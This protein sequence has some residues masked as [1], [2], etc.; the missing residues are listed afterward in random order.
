[1]QV[2]FQFHFYPQTEAIILAQIYK[3]IFAMG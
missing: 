1:M 3:I 2:L